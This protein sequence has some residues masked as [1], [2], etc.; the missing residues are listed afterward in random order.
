VGWDLRHQVLRPLLAYCT[1]PDDKWGWLWSNWWNENWQGKPKY[2]EKTCPSAI[3][4]TT[5]PTWPDPG[6]NPGRR[7][8]KRQL[9]TLD[10]TFFM[11]QRNVQELVNLYF[12][13]SHKL[14]LTFIKR[15]RWQW[16]LEIKATDTASSNG[17][18]SW[19]RDRNSVT[20][21][22][23]NFL[24]SQGRQFL[25]TCWQFQSLLLSLPP[26]FIYIT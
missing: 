16:Y 3:L 5:N 9:L 22:I 10:I 19:I 24:S 4:S 20:D 11:F 8:G 14:I 26:S 17:H 13:S 6:A 18:N 1:A 25:L 23:C 7:G 21:Y 12:S 2:S 15:Y